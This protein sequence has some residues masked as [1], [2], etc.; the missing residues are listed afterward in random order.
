MK[1]ILYLCPSLI[2]SL[3]QFLKHLYFPK[4]DIRVWEGGWADSH[5]LT[6]HGA[7]DW[8]NN[9]PLKPGTGVVESG[10]V[11]K[12]SAYYKLLIKTGVQW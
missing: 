9:P 1:I 11:K 6:W 4:P 2:G 8:L 5:A 7:L 3:S 10:E 12:I